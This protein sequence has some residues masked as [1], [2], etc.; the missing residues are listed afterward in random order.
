MVPEMQEVIGQR[1]ESM[2]KGAWMR[3]RQKMK[4]EGEE[5]SGGGEKEVEC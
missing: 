1:E 4:R 5:K 2:L 3:M